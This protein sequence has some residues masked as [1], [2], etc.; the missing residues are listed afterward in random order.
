MISLLARD[1]RVRLAVGYFAAL[2]A[3]ALGADCLAS[4]LPLVARYHAELYLLPCVWRPVALVAHDVTTLRASAAPGDWLLA[5]PVAF[6]PNE[7]DK[8]FLPYAQPAGRHWLGTDGARR[9]VLARLL[10]GSRI[11]LL[12]GF[13]P[14]L[15][16]VALG[17]LLGLCAGYFGGV[18]DVVVSRASEIVMTLPVLFLLLALAGLRGQGG[19]GS[20]VAVLS[21][22]L[23][24]RVTRLV[25][26]ETQ[27][28]RGLDYVRAAE[29]LGLSS[30]RVLTRHVLPN[31]SGPIF[32]AT[33]FGG[34]SAILIESSLSF[35][36]FGV[37][38]D[39]ATWG[40]LLHGAMG[41]LGAWW[42]VVFPGAAI[43]ATVSAFNL[44]GEAWRDVLDPRVR[45]Q[46]G[47]PMSAA[48]EKEASAW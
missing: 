18:V 23:W 19:A 11:A 6:G 1:L 17:A 33:A 27:R 22:A 41:Q 40:G 13:V 14:V 20:I 7:Q 10:H 26:A 42:L 31:A 12:M 36:G 35:V 48:V 21:A 43:F 3:V 34:A 44:L 37:P 39:V 46:A 4:P 8:G 32:V 2:G 29:G 28:V 9:D 24:P 25:R 30:W 5:T 16:Y 45:G 47:G 15:I 38:D